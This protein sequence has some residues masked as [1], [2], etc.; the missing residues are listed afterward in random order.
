MNAAAHL[1]YFDGTV[2][3]KAGEPLNAT[4]EEQEAFLWQSLIDDPCECGAAPEEHTIAEDERGRAH[5]YCP[6]PHS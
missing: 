2:C 4:Y 5:V 3:H 6:T 1:R